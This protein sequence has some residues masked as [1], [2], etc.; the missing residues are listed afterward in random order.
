[1]AAGLPGLTPA[2]DLAL[3]LHWAAWAL[4]LQLDLL[5]GIQLPDWGFILLP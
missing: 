3:V 4:I 2:A 1:M 5:A